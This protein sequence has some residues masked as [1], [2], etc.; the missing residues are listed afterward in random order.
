MGSWQGW[1]L[2]ATA[3]ERPARLDII[4]FLCSD[5]KSAK[6]SLSWNV[7]GTCIAKVFVASLRVICSP[8]LFRYLQLQLPIV[9]IFCLPIYTPLLLLI[10]MLSALFT[11][12]GT[13]RKKCSIPTWVCCSISI[14][15][16]FALIIFAN[17]LILPFRGGL[18][19]SWDIVSSETQNF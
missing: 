3:C 5:L 4:L 19:S 18:Q 16:Y 9:P 10:S 1:Y 12:R 6:Y 7:I 13:S 8:R 17:L 15:R 14:S 11:Q 2:S